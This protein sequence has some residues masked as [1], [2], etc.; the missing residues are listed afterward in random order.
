MEILWIILSVLLLAGMTLLL[1]F[2][3]FR[4]AF[5]VK[6]KKI[7]GPEDYPIPPGKEYAPFG[8]K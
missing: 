5:Y 2:I 6:Q 4:M 7:F 3:C 1:A 8:M